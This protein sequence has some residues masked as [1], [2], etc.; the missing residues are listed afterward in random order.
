MFART[1]VLTFGSL[2][3]ASLGVMS[4]PLA[5]T[6][7]A[8][9]SRMRFQAMD[10]NNDGRVTRQE[11]NGSAQSFE[12][13]D[14]N[15]DGVLSG[16][17]VRPGGRR[18]AALEPVDH[19]PNR[20]ERNLNWT[21][22]NFTNLDHNRDNRLSSN[23]WHFDIETFRRVDANRDN[24]LSLAEF[25]GEGVD[26]LRD[27]SFDNLDANN[28]G[29]VERAEW[30][31]G[32]NEFRR[33]DRNNDGILSRFEVVGSQPN[34]TTWDEFA[35]LDYDRN[36]SLSRA[37]WHWSNLSFTQRDANRDGIISRNEFAAAGG[38]PG[39]VGAIGSQPVATQT[40]RVNS[41]VRW[42]DTGLT[43]NAGDVL[44][45]ST[46]GQIQLSDNAQDMAAAAGSLTG[47]TANDAPISGVL[48]GALIGRIG[49]FSAMG[50]GNQGTIT[51]PVSGRLYLGVNDDHLP[52]NRG[53]FTVAVGVRRR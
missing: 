52:D 3:L 53:E 17:E 40:V 1:L 21:R 27:D 42:T 41:Q 14:W 25:L 18:A 38:A 30:Y 49:N 4:T 10:R 34:T 19:A 13:H 33:L 16:E 22:N 29:R 46:T 12:V 32:A 44:T 8:Q 15:N 37:E 47:R 45:F 5:T 7:E 35:G 36:G 50:I 26:D 2:T 11:W 48:A 6:A 31:G 24:N 20:F 43:V 39:A 28:N 9:V 51:A 23:E